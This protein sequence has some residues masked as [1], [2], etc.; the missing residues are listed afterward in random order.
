MMWWQLVLAI[1][2][3]EFVANLLLDSYWEAKDKKT[4]M[5]VVVLNASREVSDAVKEKIEELEKKEG[6]KK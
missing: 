3:G 5:D 1:I 4:G 2:I 6:K